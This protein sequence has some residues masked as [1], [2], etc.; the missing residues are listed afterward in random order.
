M[1]ISKIRVQ[2]KD[3][4][5]EGWDSQKIV[6]AVRK[7]AE[8][9]AVELSD[10]E[11]DIV[12]NDVIKRIEVAG[13]EIVPIERLHVY[14][15]L[16]L[17]G[18]SPQTAKQYRGYRDYKLRECRRFGLLISAGVFLVIERTLIKTRHL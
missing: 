17:D 9:A 7:S 4:R 18:V 5:L 16:A 10:A 13:T 12:V 3:K 11:C 6:R 2:K 8:R 14:V 15:E 1:D